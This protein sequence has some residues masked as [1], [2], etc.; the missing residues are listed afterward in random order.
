MQEVIWEVLIV[1]IISI[2]VLLVLIVI[3]LRQS[4]NLKFQKRIDRF[5]LQ[6]L[7][8]EEKSFFDILGI[9]LW[10]LVR[11]TSKLLNKSA[12][13]KKYS[14]KYEKHITYEERNDKTGM[15]YISTKFLLGIFTVL[16]SIFTMMFQYTKFPL[17][18]I[19]VIF[20]IGFFLPD[21]FLNIEF[22]KK[23]KKIEED[24]LKAII[25]MNSAFKSGRN[26]MQAIEIVKDELDGSISDEFQKIYIDI[27][28]GLSLEVVFNRFYER[29]KLEDVKYITSSLSLLNRTGGNIV[30]VFSMIEKTFFDKKKLRNELNSMTAS[31]VF[32][33]R[34]LISLPFVFAAII[35]VLNPTYFKIMYTTTIGFIV[36]T[37]III[38]YILYVL[39]VKKVMRVKIWEIKI[40]I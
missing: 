5:A 18:I 2:V 35:I 34:L 31:S 28:Y 1:Q 11:G 16:L 20:L 27:N 25:I 32:V 22:R 40:I 3:L 29:V 23:R 38:L 17:P 9:K 37:L 8:N 36:S 26:I 24:L 21:I 7:N 33:Y 10:N 12:V 6:P 14:E 30:K 13:L 4:K 15:D 19:L 39:V